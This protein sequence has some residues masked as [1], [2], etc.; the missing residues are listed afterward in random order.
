[1]RSYFDA[2]IRY[3]E[4]SG[5]TGRAQFWIYQLVAML[6]IIGVFFIEL[7]LTGSFHRVTQ[8]GSLYTMVALFHAI[9]GMAITVRRLHDIGKSGWWY[10]IS[11]I[12][13][14]ALFILYWNC[15][16]GDEWDNDYG[17]PNIVAVR[18][19]KTSL[20]AQRLD[21]AKGQS[22]AEVQQ[23]RQPPTEGR[24]I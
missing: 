7:R 23:R 15:C 17:D 3:F 5:R 19:Q 4:F 13:F 18:P 22:P 16:A 11:F 9:P 12:P 2:M 14:G 8:L 20:A 24:F 10:L 6:I 1:M 21:A